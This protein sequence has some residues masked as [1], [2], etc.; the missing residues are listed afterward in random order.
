MF[1]PMPAQPDLE[2]ERSPANGHPAL[3]SNLLLL[4]HSHPLIP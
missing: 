4:N 2:E 3:S 1:H